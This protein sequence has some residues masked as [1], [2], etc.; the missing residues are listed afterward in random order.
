MRQ[1][2]VKSSS[3][4]ILQSVSFGVKEM[5]A[6]I[7][8]G[9]SLGLDFSLCFCWFAALRALLKRMLLWSSCF[10][11]LAS[12]D[13][14]GQGCLH[15]GQACSPSGENCRLENLAKYFVAA[16]NCGSGLNI[17]RALSGF[18][19][20]LPC[21]FFPLLSLVIRFCCLQSFKK[22]D[23]F[24]VIK[25][26]HTSDLQIATSQEERHLGA[27]RDRGTMQ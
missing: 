4:G 13:I 21:N 17:K 18:P 10:F 24:S 8:S 3:G 19:P 27:V 22:L 11:T 25:I 26:T 2:W 23:C 14:P 1:T 15:S 6:G 12:F 20:P 7:C 9:Q 16:V 5:E